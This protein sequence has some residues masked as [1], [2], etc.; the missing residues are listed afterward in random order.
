MSVTRLTM[1]DGV[2]LAVESLGAGRPVVLV[3][4]FLSHAAM[5][6][7][8]PGI[9]ARLVD[10]GFQV[11]MPEFRGHG[12]SDTP[13]DPALYPPDVLTRDI[14]GVIAVLGLTD[15]D[16]VGY[17]LGARTS[18]RV[19][20]R[21]NVPAPR[22]LVLGGMGLSGLLESTGRRDWFVDTIRRREEPDQT[23]AQ[24]TVTRFI[25]ATR[26]NPEA[27]VLA[28]LS[29]V[30]S[31]ADDLARLALPVLVVCGEAD[32]DNGSAPDLAAAIPGATL[33]IVPGTHM[34]VIVAPAFA[35]AIADFLR[36]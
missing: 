4:G 2:S 18:L 15:Y 5:N 11:I 7:I 35:A 12:R 29:Q 13:T 24:Q 31:R 8:N 20:L 36:A 33:A 27:A 19:V 23:P 25:K 14:E 3:H 17:S 16:L 34:S 10:A 1:A 21:G 26:S 28:L 22:R 9:A 30:D 32:Q 6:W